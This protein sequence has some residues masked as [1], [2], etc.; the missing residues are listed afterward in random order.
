M[1]YE[2]L[3]AR[4]SERQKPA[5]DKR[6]HGSLKAVFHQAGGS[7]AHAHDH[8]P[9]R[10]IYAPT[11]LKTSAKPPA[12][13]PSLKYALGNFSFG[14]YFK[15]EAISWAW[16]YITKVL[17]IPEERLYVTVYQDDDEAE[18][19]WHE[20]IGL[21]ME[22]IFRMGKEDNFWEAGID[23]PCGPCSEILLRPWTRIRLWQAR[24]HRRLRLRQIHG[25]SG[26]LYSPSSSRHEDGTYT[27][28][29]PDEHR[30]RHGTWSVW[31]L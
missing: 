15:E 6:G 23:G 27:P 8:L 2:K 16:E 18:R 26:T 30:H 20:K 12:T 28:S 13:A 10:R 11:I 9:E 3:S 17:E 29:C 1:R 24:L 7:A 4:S 14:D 22:K 21:P 31:R 25:S 19:I 5:V